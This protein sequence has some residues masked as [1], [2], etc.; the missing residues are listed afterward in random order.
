MVSLFTSWGQ[1]GSALMY[2]IIDSCPVQVYAS[3]DTSTQNYDSNISPY[4]SSVFSDCS[5]AVVTGY[6]EAAINNAVSLLE[7]Q[8]V[9]IPKSKSITCAASDLAAEI[10]NC[11]DNSISVTAITITSG[12]LSDA[13]KTAISN[14]ID[15]GLADNLKSLDLT[16]ATGSDISTYSL[17]ESLETVYLPNG[18]TSI[19]SNVSA[20]ASKNLKIAFAYAED[21]NGNVTSTVLPTVAGG[22]KAFHQANAAKFPGGATIKFANGSKLNED[23]FTWLS[24]NEHN[25]P[26]GTNSY[27]VDMFDID[28]NAIMYDS[29]KI[30]D[31]IASGVNTMRAHT[32]NGSPSFFGLILP[33]NVNTLGT[34]LIQDRVGDTD[35]QPTSAQFIAYYN[36]TSTEGEQVTVGHV[37]DY[38][39]NAS[40][41]TANFNKMMAMLN[42][43][44]EVS[45]TTI[46]Q[47]STNSPTE[48]PLTSLATSTTRIETYNNEMV[49]AATKATMHVY[50]DEADAL[51]TAVDN[52]GIENTPV[53]KLV[54]EGPVSDDDLKSIASFAGASTPGPRVLDLSKVTGGVT[55]AQLKLISNSAI[56]YLVLPKDADKDVIFADYTSKMPNLK[57]VINAAN[58]S[59]SHPSII[60]NV[61]EAGKLYEARCHALGLS[62]STDGNYYLTSNTTFDVTSVTLKGNLNAADINTGAVTVGSDGHFKAT[63]AEGTTTSG[64]LG[65]TV[66]TLDL[67][68]AVFATQTDMNFSGV[69][70]SSLTTLRLPIA[71]SMNQITE[72]CLYNVQTLTQLCIPSN[73]K[74]IG[75]DALNLCG[76]LTIIT[77]SDDHSLFIG[78][79]GDSYLTEEEAFAESANTYTFSKNITKIE[80]GAF[81]TKSTNLSDIYIMATTTP[82][83]EK[84][85]FAEGM[86]VGWLGFTGG[87]Y[88]YCR[89][90]YRNGS[91]LY[92]VLHY[93]AQGS[94]DDATYATMEKQY[95]DVTKVY[96]KKEQSG[97]KDANG[98]DIAWPTFS[99]LRRVYAQASAS[100]TWHDWKTAYDGLYEVNETASTEGKTV[101]NS[102]TGET[103]DFDNYI[104]WHQFVL[105]MANYY[106]PTEEVVDEKIV[107][108]YE[109]AGLYTFC[110]P[111]NMT[112]EQVVEWL[113][114]PKSTDKVINRLKGEQVD[115]NIMPEI[116]QL[117]SV[118]REKGTGGNNNVVTFRLT[119]NLFN[120]YH[121]QNSIYTYYLNVD[122]SGTTP[123]INVVNAQPHNNEIAG[124]PITLVAGRPY[125]IKAY[126]RVNVVN[127]VD[128]YK[129]SGQNIANEIMTRYGNKFELKQ[130]AVENGLYEQLG[131]DPDATTLRFAIPYEGHKIQAMKAGGNSAYLEYTEDGK[132]HK[133]Y[134]TMVGQY[135]EQPLPLY[136]IYMA[137]GKWYR[138]TDKTKGYMWD[139]YKCIIMATKE[140]VKQSDDQHYGGGYRDAELVN[141]PNITGTDKLDGEFKLGYLDGRD[142]D[143]FENFENSKYMFAFDDDIVEIDD[144]GNESTAIKQ[145]NGVDLTI[146]PDN[147]KVYNMSGQYVGNSL[148]GLGK[149]MYIVNGK[150]YVVK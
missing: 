86:Y 15:G 126:K 72:R 40:A 53:E 45:G 38:N 98:R 27:Y 112:Y 59:T 12:T 43:H 18:T 137:R 95:T 26:R 1:G 113:G 92:T 36:N 139:P 20:L 125:I 74:V 67:T 35:P 119:K 22:F 124:N 2:I 103:Y 129:I 64:L 60:A 115:E 89:E 127:G 47:I 134:Y 123:N 145:L 9:T 34:T 136:S 54:I 62:I 17:P 84:D 116:H 56:E 24:I 37:Y 102:I 143:D 83:C 76:A 66:T 14:L 130:S 138:Y 147:C 7:A 33:K 52:T 106:E 117:L 149:G 140:L 128:E 28:V 132:T 108:D 32:N 96:T 93:P 61:L 80:T 110:I 58:S 91:I 48:F 68:E 133:Y 146:Q 70:L 88:P 142:D 69:G 81:Q 19:P 55:E 71:S 105:T 79:N 49:K 82:L 65:E 51:K 101:D 10:Q 30:E 120:Y 104:G 99:E 141:I 46:Y 5:N 121:E 11:I 78:K 50:T 75:K 94:M 31:V 41:Y 77:D 57:A 25:N 97:A 144:E 150:K 6:N 42:A 148:N 90:K 39:T 44:S 8:G 3:K 118:E 100:L 23:D 111:F 85:A 21:A 107:R 73:Y 122:N 29:K 16:G 109:E 114:V 135:W 13:D 4:V 131:D 87:D 63:G